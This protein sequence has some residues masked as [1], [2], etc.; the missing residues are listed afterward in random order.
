MN[1]STQKVLD[2]MPGTMIELTERTGFPMR[3][4]L[5]EIVKTRILGT[6]VTARSDLGVTVFTRE[7]KEQTQ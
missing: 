3:V 5:A 1:S 7:P 6:R 4:V 2:A